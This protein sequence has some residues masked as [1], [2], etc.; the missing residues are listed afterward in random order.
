MKLYIISCSYILYTHIYQN[1]D[2]KTLTIKG[3][4]RKNQGMPNIWIDYEVKRF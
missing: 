3:N 4:K 2:N 1:P